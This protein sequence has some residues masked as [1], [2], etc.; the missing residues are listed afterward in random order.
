MRGVMLLSEAIAVARSELV[1]ATDA[2]IPRYI[3]CLVWQALLQD[4][5]TPASRSRIAR[6]EGACV[7]HVQP[8]WDAAHPG[9]PAVE[10]RLQLAEDLLE[11]RVVLPA[12]DPRLDL[13]AFIEWVTSHHGG[14]YDS[15]T[16]PALFV[17]DAAQRA[18][19]TAGWAAR[20][21]GARSFL[22]CPEGYLDADDDPWSTAADHACACA[23]G[24]APWEEPARVDLA[25]RRRFWTWWLD[26]AVPR[27]AH[28]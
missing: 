18:L 19:I 26:V 20:G 2:T 22:D 24:G 4:P 11:G 14:E 16:A 12:E 23:V 3:R 13:E 8:I 6:L 15:A 7:R 25:A 21:H 1:K 10:Q 27:A 9:D 5:G 17:L 28:P